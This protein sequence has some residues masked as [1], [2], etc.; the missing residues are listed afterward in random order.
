[1]AWN[2]GLTGTHLNIAAYPKTPLRVMAGP[3]TGKTYAVMRR[4]ARWL[5]EGCSPPR[6]LAVSFTRTAANDLVS[7]LRAL[8]TPGADGVVAST[9][10]AL[11][12]SILA[13]SSVLQTIGRVARPLMPFE[14]DYML[15]DLAV[16]FGGKRSAQRLLRA[17]ETGWATL[18]HQQPGWPQDPTEQGFQRELTRWL[19]YHQAMHV[20]ELVPLALDYIRRNPASPDAP[21][22]DHTVVD[23]Y[24]DLNR[25]DQELADALARDGSITVVGD[26]DQSIYTGLRHARPEAIVGFHNTHA[27]THDEPLSESRRCPQRVVG[28]ANALILHNHPRRPSTVVPR[29]SNPVGDIY[30]VQHRSLD[31]EINASAAFVHWYLGKPGTRPGDVL[32]LSTRRAIGNAIRDELVR[33]GRTARSFFAEDC[34][35]KTSAQEGY[36]LLTLLVRPD[37]RTALRVWLGA[38][39]NN[40]RVRAY[41]R[42][43]QAA[44]TAGLGPRQLLDSI[45][46]GS[47]PAPA[48]TD[49]LVTR[50]QQMVAGVR[51]LLG[52]STAEVVDQLWPP[53]G[54]CDDIRGVALS[55]ATTVQI[56]ADLLK[57][58]ETTLIQPELPGGREDVVR[59]MSLHKS[60]GLTA[61]C[62]LV[63]G[64]MAG[65]LPTLRPDLS[66]AATQQAVEEA[67]RLFYVAITRTTNTLAI[68]SSATTPYAKAMHLRLTPARSIRGSAILQASPFISELGNQ[69]ATVAGAR[70][71]ATLGF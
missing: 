67:R 3:G 49:D 12:F 60:K 70:W 65:A 23:E 11:A 4:V 48:Y 20:G 1:M 8:N 19:S 57:E 61:K 35:D 53:G 9:L 24:Q 52:Q 33:M 7:Q 39:E 62:V 54:D 2:T 50:Y 40:Q 42:L 32:V 66:P 51:G 10:H 64:C 31:E 22:Y 30:V 44:E 63:T 71:R 21:S 43:W 17:F 26:E 29:P 47:T 36:C 25:A 69:V 15:A 59:I 18:Q 55:I 68:S 38:D 58:L 41:A 6:V 34:L 13:K 37:D 46:G 14:T 45:V 27:N 28:M 5:E 16:G 56:P